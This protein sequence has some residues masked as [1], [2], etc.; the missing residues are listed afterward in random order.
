M[1]MIHSQNDSLRVTC[2]LVEDK[3]GH[4]HEVKKLLEEPKRSRY[5][6]VWMFSRAPLLRN[7][8]PA[9]RVLALTK[10]AVSPRAVSWRTSSVALETDRLVRNDI[11]P[12][13]LRAAILLHSMAMIIY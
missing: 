5:A 11:I 9:Q 10:K 4:R 2:W 13:Q 6:I 12:R 8:M 7:W 1:R 3:V